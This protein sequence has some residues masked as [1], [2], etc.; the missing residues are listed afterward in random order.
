MAAFQK[1]K[2]DNIP[3]ASSMSFGIVVSEWH[4]E[5]TDALLDGA[6]NALTANGVLPSNIMV[7]HVPGSF[8]LTL[9]A[10]YFIN[11]TEVDAVICL[12][13]VIQGET[14]HFQY[15]CQS[16]TQ[17]ITELNLR[18][19]IPLTFG[20]L[21]TNNFDQA[22]A[23]SGGAKGNKGEEAAIAAIKMVALK[24]DFLSDEEG[25]DDEDN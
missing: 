3:N 20:I 25:N 2:T 11:Y 15:I 12:G 22:K 14:P 10:E 23:R 5:I 4:P 21:T 13:C 18:F 24:D 19:G 8:E 1:L 9:G 17:G 16:L 7:K 6:V